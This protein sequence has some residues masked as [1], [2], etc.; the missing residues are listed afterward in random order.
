[1]FHAILGDLSTYIWLLL[2]N[3]ASWFTGG[4]AAALFY[5]W[6]RYWGKQHSWRIV[7]V[8]FLFTFVAGSY[9][10][11]HDEYAQNHSRGVTREKHVAQLQKFYG[12]I[13]ALIDE[14]LPKDISEADFNKYMATA[15]DWENNATQW[16]ELNMG[17][18]ARD[19]FLDRSGIM[20]SLYSKRV[21]DVHNTALLNLTRQ[22]ENLKQLIENPIW[23]RGL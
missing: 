15:E 23:D 8:F 12:E 17:I 10:T 13:G 4:V 6:E 18:A 20:A 16:I 14:P 11:W 5:G 9:Q 1:M 2:S 22:R 21:N 3:W 7:A 19:H